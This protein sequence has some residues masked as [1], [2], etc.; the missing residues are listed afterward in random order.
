MV[1]WVR[2]RAFG[3]KWLG[4]SAKKSLSGDETGVP[5]PQTDTGRRVE[6]TK[7]NERHLV[8]ELGKIAP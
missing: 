8:K 7:A 1:E 6:D 2:K 3:R 5:V 4:V